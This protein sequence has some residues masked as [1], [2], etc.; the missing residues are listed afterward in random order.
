[1]SEKKLLD[2]ESVARAIFLPAMLSQL[3]GKCYMVIED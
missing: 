3:A 1:M 2:T